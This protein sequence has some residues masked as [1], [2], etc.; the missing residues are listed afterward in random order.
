MRRTR[1]SEEQV[2]GILKEP[3]RGERWTRWTRWRAF[4][5]K[6]PDLPIASS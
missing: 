6:A 3:R 4:F 2:I 1:F 5:N